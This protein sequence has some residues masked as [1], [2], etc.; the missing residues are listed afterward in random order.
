MLY[1]SKQRRV[2]KN[3]TAVGLILS[4]QRVQE[5]RRFRKRRKRK[6]VRTIQHGPCASFNHMRFARSAGLQARIAFCT[7]DEN[8]DTLAARTNAKRNAK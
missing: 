1:S 2:S 4:V 6:E 3:Y 7:Q 8:D 5:I